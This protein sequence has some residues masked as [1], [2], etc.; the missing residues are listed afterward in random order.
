MKYSMEFSK[1][2]EELPGRM[3]TFKSKLSELTSGVEK[4]EAETLSDVVVKKAFDS[5]EILLKYSLA[6]RGAK[7]F[8]MGA[9]I[10]EGYLGALFYSMK[11]V[12]TT[13]ADALR[14]QQTAMIILAQPLFLAVPALYY[15]L[16]S[17]KIRNN[18]SPLLEPEDFTKEN[19]KWLDEQ[20]KDLL[21]ELKK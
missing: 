3:F 14:M 5:Y 10:A 1:I 13:A 12:P 8:A 7:Y 15:Y 16:K 6:R 20:L 21:S 19:R 2:A 18:S 9:V 11:D 4:L 17:R